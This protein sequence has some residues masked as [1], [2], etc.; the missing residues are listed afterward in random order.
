MI[1]DIISFWWGRKLPPTYQHLASL[2]KPDLTEDD[3]DKLRALRTI[4][5]IGEAL[6]LGPKDLDWGQQVTI[7]ETFASEEEK[8]A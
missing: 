3:I 5:K 8:D 7:K 4:V 2:A 6:E 1:N